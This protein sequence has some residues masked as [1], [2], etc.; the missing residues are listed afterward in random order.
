MKYDL[1]EL[2]EKFKLLVECRVSSV[3]CRVS[4]VECRVSSVECII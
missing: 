4:S 1:K 2:F 3:E